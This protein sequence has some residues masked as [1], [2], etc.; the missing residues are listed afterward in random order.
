MKSLFG[1][2]AVRLHEKI[3]HF[4]S[5]FMMGGRSKARGDVE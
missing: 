2:D 4:M 3:M 1:R 5:E